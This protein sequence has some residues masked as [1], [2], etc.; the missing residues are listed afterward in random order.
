[1]L[2]FLNGRLGRGTCNYNYNYLIAEADWLRGFSS[3][4]CG[5]LEYESFGKSDRD[6]PVQ[7]GGSTK[8]K[9]FEAQ[10]WPLKQSA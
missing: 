9:T 1:V 5:Y 6:A 3:L 4:H 2:G 8:K 10:H 7:T